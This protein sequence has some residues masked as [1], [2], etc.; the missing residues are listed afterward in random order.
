M[1]FS[2]NDD[3]YINNTAWLLPVSFRLCFKNLE[4]LEVQAVHNDL[5]VAILFA[6]ATQVI[7]S[8]LII[9]TN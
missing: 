1:F 2:C 4:F 6:N 8:F 3:N 5:C 7:F 9:L